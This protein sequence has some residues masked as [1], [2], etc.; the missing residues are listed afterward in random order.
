M[1]FK[2]GVK[3]PGQ[4]EG[5]PT[6]ENEHRYHQLMKE[7]VTDEDFKAVVVSLVTEAKRG[8]IWATRMIFEYLIGK[9]EQL[10]NINQQVIS[11]TKTEIVFRW[12]NSNDG[13]GHSTE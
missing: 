4:G 11:D 3:I 8:S 7:A 6:R 2:K 13:S 1:T 5:R 12:D 9:P 10:L